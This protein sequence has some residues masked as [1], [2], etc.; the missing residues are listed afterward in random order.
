MT[1]RTKT[2]RIAAVCSVVL[3]G[4]GVCL[5]T[6]RAALSPHSHEAVRVIETDPRSPEYDP[7]ELVR[8]LDADP[9]GVVISEPRVTEFAARR[10]GFLSDKVRRLLDSNKL[11]VALDGV[12]CFASSCVIRVSS[13]EA[14]DTVVHDVTTAL[15]TVSPLF[16]Y[17][18]RRSPPQRYGVRRMEFAVLFRPDSR[19]H[20]GYERRIEIPQLSSGQLR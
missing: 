12:V 6:A 14:G 15:Q 20:N 10:E 2:A 18:T 4:S 8:A 19:A 1:N 17:I 7:I 9:W 11:P 16:D 13:A 5:W 3:I